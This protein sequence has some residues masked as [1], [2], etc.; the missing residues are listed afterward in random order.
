MKRYFPGRAVDAVGAFALGATLASASEIFGQQFYW[1]LLVVAVL[2]GSYAIIGLGVRYYHWV[3]RDRP[4]ED[5]IRELIPRVPDDA[6]LLLDFLEVSQ[7]DTPEDRELRKMASF[8]LLTAA[9]EEI[10]LK[11]SRVRG[12]DPKIINQGELS[13]LYP[14]LSD[15]SIT[16]VSGLYGVHPTY[17]NVTLPFSDV[18]KLE[19][20]I[21]TYMSRLLGEGKVSGAD[22]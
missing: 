16:L 13:D 7:R 20:L 5:V 21:E 14:K 1:V 12:S 22:G 19:K 15:G 9:D 17:F 6:H 8:I 18:Q 10:A 4:I 2:C 3:R 11:G